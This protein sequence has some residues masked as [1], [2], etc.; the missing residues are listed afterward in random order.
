MSKRAQQLQS[1]FDVGNKIGLEIAKTWGIVNNFHFNRRFKTL[2]LGNPSFR[3]VAR[4]A[5][6]IGYATGLDKA[7]KAAEVQ[8]DSTQLTGGLDNA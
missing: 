1:A 5:A 3:G 7:A 6:R 8:D 4:K 2:Y